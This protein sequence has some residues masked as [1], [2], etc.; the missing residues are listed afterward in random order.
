[1][2]K[3]IL[4]ISLAFLLV[5]FSANGETIGDIDGDGQ[6]GLTESIYSL[7]VVAGL[8]TV[9]VEQAVIAV[10]PVFNSSL[11]GLGNVIEWIESRIGTLSKGRVEINIVDTDTPPDQ[12]LSL[13]SQGTLQAAHGFAGY[14][15]IPAAELFGS[16][17]FGPEPGEYL[18]WILYG[19]GL[20]LWQKLYDDEGYNVK[21]IPCGITIGET[22]GW[23]KNPVSSVTDFNGL[24]MRACGLGAL[25]LQKLGA[26]IVTCSGGCQIRNLLE[27]GTIEAA[28]FSFPSI[29]QLCDFGSVASYNYFPGWHQ[30]SILMEFLINKE[31]WAGLTPHQ[32]M[33]IEIA[34]KAA[35]VDNLAYTEAIQSEYIALN[36]SK[37]VQNLYFSDEI[38]N[39]L[40]AAA[41]EVMEEQRNADLAFKTIWD[42]YT[43][44]HQSYSVWSNLGFNPR[45]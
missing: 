27:N 5:G 11:M 20:N 29:E 1:V 36:A 2:K 6:V 28:E 18:A 35:T 24:K 32:Q 38:L 9:E 39:S 23:Y 25:T 41:D 15:N 33:A 34:C 31:L 19:N 16:F 37:G 26:I 42:D 30:R 14:H 12:V 22:G 3:S 21:V 4:M 13:V 40:K 44:F 45:R 8:K 43:Q 7:Q 17:P 10:E